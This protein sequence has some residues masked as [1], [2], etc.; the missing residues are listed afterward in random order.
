MGHIIDVRHSVGTENLTFKSWKIISD[1]ILICES[2]IAS[3]SI[4]VLI[5][6][7]KDK[8]TPAGFNAFA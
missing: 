3:F 5:Q 2:Y 4:N 6:A 1:L 7:R 8:M